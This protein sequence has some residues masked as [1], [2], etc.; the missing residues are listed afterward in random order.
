MSERLSRFNANG[1]AA[2]AR[3]IRGGA[4]D[5]VPQDLICDKEFIDPLDGDRSVPQAAFRD[6]YD[7]GVALV[8][9][10]A[11]YEQQQVSFDRGL[12]T[13][14]AA[15][16]FEQI[17]PRDPAGRRV[18]RK[19]YVYVLSESR[20]YYRHLVRTP[21]SLVKTHAERCRFLLASRIGDLAPLSR[22]TYLLDAL[23][24]RQFVISSPALVGAAARLYSDPH[25]GLPTRGAGAR[26]PGS[27][28]RLALLANQLSLTY[29]IHEMPIDSL[30][31]LLP[32]E[33]RVPG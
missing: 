25:T 33:F 27:P 7:F 23:A 3:W 28:R 31:A 24:A 32:G 4:K 1:I 6:R 17:C 2:F 22:Q 30:L 5:A 19:E 20:L 12:W 14:L 9:L 18:L 10:L 21:W 29:D 8:E 13:W 11:A 15:Y 16:Y 26:G